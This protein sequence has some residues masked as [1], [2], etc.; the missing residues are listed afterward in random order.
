MRIYSDFLNHYYNI[1]H[2]LQ[3]DIWILI[4][5][6]YFYILFY[7]CILPQISID[8]WK[9]YIYYT[10]YFLS[11]KIALKIA[12]SFL[13][14][15][16]PVTTDQYHFRQSETLGT[17]LTYSE[18][19]HIWREAGASLGGTWGAVAP[20]SFWDLL[21]RFYKKN[22]RSPKFK[23][24]TW[25]LFIFLHHSPFMIFFGKLLFDPHDPPKSP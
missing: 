10:Q 3:S 7:I 9:R 13:F 12:H 20:L 2:I 14:E 4:E 23:M 21:N 15:W 8:I 6:I 17:L 5:Q 24:L 11:I 1:V 16:T 22:F 18:V 25:P 19:V